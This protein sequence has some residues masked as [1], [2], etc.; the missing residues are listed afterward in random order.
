MCRRCGLTLT[1]ITYCKEAKEELKKK[2]GIGHRECKG[3][4]RQGIMYKNAEDSLYVKA[5][6]NVGI[7]ANLCKPVTIHV[8]QSLMRTRCLLGPLTT[9]AQR[10]ICPG[11]V[12]TV[13]VDNS[14]VSG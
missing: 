2:H 1:R 10:S 13:L 11:R 3:F 14:K 8:G 5:R 12:K 9:S 4:N 6:L 7:N